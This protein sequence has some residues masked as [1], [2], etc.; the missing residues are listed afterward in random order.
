MKDWMQKSQNHLSQ[1][2][3]E[4]FITFEFTKSQIKKILQKDLFTPESFHDTL[5]NTIYNFTYQA[6]KFEEQNFDKEFYR[7][8]AFTAISLHKY[9]EALEF[10]KI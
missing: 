1:E 4:M 5:E 2:F 8:M 9:D 10:A 7:K 6:N 3:R